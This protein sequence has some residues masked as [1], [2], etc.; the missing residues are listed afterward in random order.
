MSNNIKVSV[1]V[2]PLLPRELKAK[3]AEGEA[4]PVSLVSMPPSDPHKVL[5][6][7]PKAQSKNNISIDNKPKS[8]LFDECIW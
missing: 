1:R 6:T 2:R 3:K 4:T 5:L 7:N 8:F